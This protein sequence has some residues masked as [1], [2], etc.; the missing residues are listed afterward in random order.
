MVLGPGGRAINVPLLAGDI[1]YRI[2]VNLHIARRGRTMG[3]TPF[4]EALVEAGFRYVRIGTQPDDD[5][6]D[7]IEIVNALTARSVE[8]TWVFADYTTIRR[9]A[10]HLRHPEWTTTFENLN[11]N[12]HGYEAALSTA[13]ELDDLRRELGWGHVNIT[14]PSTGSN[15]DNRVDYAQGLPYTDVCNVH[16]YP[17][18]YSTIDT[19]AMRNNLLLS[20][21]WGQGYQRKWMTE[22]GLRHARTPPGPYP[23]DAIV[24]DVP[25]GIAL[26]RNALFAISVP[27]V[28]KFA[29][30]LFSD[31]PSRYDTGD[32]A[33]YGLIEADGTPKASYSMFS[34]L[35]AVLRDSD[36][37]GTPVSYR[38]SEGPNIVYTL[39]VAHSDGRTFIAFWQF[40]TTVTNQPGG[41][42]QPW[43][44]GT[45]ALPDPRPVSFTFDQPVGAVR[46]LRIADVGP[47]SRVE[48]TGTTVH[49]EAT[50]DVQLLEVEPA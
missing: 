38:C 8:L 21:T 17:G 10:P 40:N 23:N 47:T 33:T 41:G 12:T 27:S 20:S 44:A 29:I 35:F 26:V 13:F 39:A 42:G 24:P 28:E 32:N 36:R 46:T 43:P 1:P 2:G 18:S 19:T 3:N 7:T 15:W 5:P 4:T 45:L 49:V 48:G 34:N 6:T 37:G 25:A 31:E 22:N 9:A 14:Y 16:Y 30:Y 11:E 50:G